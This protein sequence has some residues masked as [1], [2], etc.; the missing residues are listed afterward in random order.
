MIKHAMIAY[1]SP[2]H[3]GNPKAFLE[4][5]KQYD[6]GCDVHVLSDC[7]EYEGVIRCQNP[8]VVNK[9]PR[10]RYWAANHVFLQ[11]LLFAMERGYQYFLFAEDD[12]RFKGDGWGRLLWDEFFSYPSA[13]VGGT[14][15]AHNLKK[16][17]HAIPQII[18]DFAHDYFKASQTPMRVYGHWPGVHFF[19]NGSLSFHHTETC[20]AIFRPFGFETDINAAAMQRAPYDVIVGQSL[21]RQHGLS[22]LNY[23]APSTLSYSGFGDK[24]YSENERIAML[25]SGSK[26][27]I[28]PVKGSYIPT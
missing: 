12:T 14:P 15:A 22:M 8:E 25:E 6:P 28:H 19:A 27:G 13:K 16:S 23:F 5:L 17:C 21:S 10:F 4:N 2:P 24:V 3:R 7:T 1:A 26:L 18:T 20:A 9:N 11:S